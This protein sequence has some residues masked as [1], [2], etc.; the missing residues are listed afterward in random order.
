MDWS[1]TL[2]ETLL[3]IETRLN[4]DIAKT[5]PFYFGWNPFRDWNVNVVATGKN[6]SGSTLAETLLGIET[7]STA[8]V[9]RAIL[10]STLAETLLGIETQRILH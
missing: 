10:S 5:K 1:S 3:G 4:K 2:A 9:P 7:I 8:R 6:L